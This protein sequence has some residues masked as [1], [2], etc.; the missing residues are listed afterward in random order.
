[1]PMWVVLARGPKHMDLRMAV[2]TL[3]VNGIKKVG[4]AKY[5]ARGG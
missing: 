5:L 4:V 2:R 3:V 1:L